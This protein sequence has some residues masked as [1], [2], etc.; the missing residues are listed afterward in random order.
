MENNTI[1]L[2]KE[3]VDYCL[4]IDQIYLDPNNPRFTS[5]K[6]DEISDEK[7]TDEAIQS[8]TR[9]KLEDEFS[10]HKLVENIETNGF[11]PIDRVIVKNIKDDKFVVLEG[12]RRICAAKIILEKYNNYPELVNEDVL[13]SIKK[14]QCLVYTGTDAQPAWIF[15][16]LRHIIGIQEW[17]AYNKAKLLVKLMEDDNLSL[18]EVGKKFGLTSYGAAQWIRGYFAF[19]Q[20]A[21][22]SD[23]TREVDEKAYPYFQEIFSRSNPI[24]KDWMKWNDSEFHFEDN[25]KF[26]EFLSWLYP[27]D[28][29]IKEEGIEL[30]GDWDN[31]KI[32]RSNDIRIISYL[33]RE[34]LSDFDM[35]RN[36][37]D[38]EKAQNSANTKKYLE[39]QDPSI[40]TLDK[41]KSCTKALED[42]P[43]KLVLKKKEELIDLL[44]RLQVQM[45]EIIEA[46]R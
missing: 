20:A 29:E 11:L 14:I 5:L 16:G 2:N 25:L 3:L 7:I 22:E 27:R 40:N 36:D 43:L 1:T 28:E 15:Q 23:Y 30:L 10:I 4:E 44:N 31:R 35:F 8:I 33:L 19:M 37:G 46:C 32:K 38:L 9:Q 45:K 39:S 12:N 17:P 41:I 13:E 26:N 34:S 21:E 6:W 24:F 18:S 42:I